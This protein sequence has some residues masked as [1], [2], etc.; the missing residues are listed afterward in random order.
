MRLFD[1]A[2]LVRF[3]LQGERGLFFADKIIVQEFLLCRFLADG[4][5]KLAQKLDGAHAGQQTPRLLHTAVFRQNAVEQA[6]GLQLILPVRSQ[7]GGV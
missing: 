7:S 2:L 5:V 3:G 4:A 6:N 1:D